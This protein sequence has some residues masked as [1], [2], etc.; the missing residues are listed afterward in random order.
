[1]GSCEKLRLERTA[2]QVGEEPHLER[3]ALGGG[4]AFRTRYRKV[5]GWP[6]RRT[7][8]V[9]SVPAFGVSLL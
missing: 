4:A 7:S 5:M 6:L 8:T 3:T 9:A 2:L 1:M